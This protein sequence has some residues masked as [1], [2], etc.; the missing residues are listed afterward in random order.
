[1]KGKKILS[2]FIFMIS[3]FG[4][5]GGIKAETLTTDEFMPVVQLYNGDVKVREL[6]VLRDADENF[7]YCLDMGAP[8]PGNNTV[9]TKK[10]EALEK[11]AEYAY[12]INNASKIQKTENNKSKIQLTE[13][14]EFNLLSDQAY[15]NYIK[16]QL[17]I[18]SFINQ[19]EYSAISA[20]VN[21]IYTGIPELVAEAQDDEINKYNEVKVTI[22]GKNTMTL[23]E[24][25]Q[26]YQS[27]SLTIT[28][29]QGGNIKLSIISE[30]IEGIEIY[31]EAGEKVTEI[32]SGNK[33]IVKVPTASVK[34]EKINLKLKAEGTGKK[35]SVYEY[36][37]ENF[38]TVGKLEEEEI[39]A[40]KEF[41]LGTEITKT[42]TKFSKISVVNQKELP[43]ATLRILD[44]NKEPLKDESGNL[45][46]WVSTDEPHY[47]EGL[48]AGKYYLQEL[49]APEGYVLSD[50]IV[51]F[52]V[53]EDGSITEVIMENDLQVEV[54]DTLSSRS[55]LLLVIGMIDIAL[56][57]GILLYVKKNKATE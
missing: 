34:S 5:C 10:T 18:W 45:Y 9:M 8:F 47:I 39:I 49:I 55:I 20:D 1:M 16:A 57:I 27:E 48:P 26:S 37:K 14:G 7:L 11:S 25:G 23:S 40:S 24:D 46:E 28:S 12:I 2:I 3:L 36:T 33:V 54:P 53:K 4:L 6:F 38:Q 31:N 52:E 41:E 43:G 17:A 42:K 21:E 56:G 51:E 30:G 13:G 15:E 29:S 50:E 22:T 32:A 44:E 35:Y 19:S